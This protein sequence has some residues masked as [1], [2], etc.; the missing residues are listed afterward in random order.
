MRNETVGGKLVPVA[1]RMGGVGSL[2]MSCLILQMHKPCDTE[3]LYK[4]KDSICL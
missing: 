2:C 1:L 3:G 4:N